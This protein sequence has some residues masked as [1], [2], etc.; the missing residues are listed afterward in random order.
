MQKIVRF[1]VLTLASAAFSLAVGAISLEAMPATSRLRQSTDRTSSHS[2]RRTIQTSSHQ[3]SARSRRTSRAA[4]RSS[5]HARP[6]M[7]LARYS[8]PPQQPKSSTTTKKKRTRR[9]RR[10]RRQS[11]QKAPT[12]E[13]ISEIQSALARGGYYQGDANGKWDSNTVDS[14]QKFQTANGLEP[15]GKLDALTL[16]KMGLGSDIAGVSAPKPLPPVGSAPAS[17]PRPPASSP[18]IPPVPLHSTPPATA[19]ANPST[20]AAPSATAAT[21]SNATPPAPP[22]A[23]SSAAPPASFTSSASTSSSPR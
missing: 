13:R 17:A 16:Q 21:G 14:L 15:S 5:A 2:A 19:P 3:P 23:D 18:A 10:S 20:S 11:Y 8:R 6:G 22:H 4:T 1:A 7:K 9:R 12:P